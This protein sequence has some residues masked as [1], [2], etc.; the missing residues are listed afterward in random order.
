MIEADNEFE[1]EET[2]KSGNRDESSTAKAD[3]NGK[4]S[5]KK[6]TGGDAKPKKEEKAEPMDV[7]EAAT[8]KDASADKG[9]ET[10]AAST[11]NTILHHQTS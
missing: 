1:E 8:A 4:D 5:D 10:A 7:D 3:S 11:W 6:E 9:K 2:K